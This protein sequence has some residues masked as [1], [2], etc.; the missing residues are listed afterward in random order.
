MI[1]TSSVLSSK[2]LF[3]KTTWLPDI[4]NQCGGL[5]AELSSDF[6][7]SA[8]QPGI[9]P[10]WAVEVGGFSLVS[11]ATRLGATMGHYGRPETT[12]FRWSVGQPDWGP[13][14]ATW[15]GGFPL[16]SGATRES[17]PQGAQGSPASWHSG[18]AT[19]A[20]E[21]PL[22][23]QGNHPSSA[24]QPSSTSLVVSFWRAIL[25]RLL[26]APDSSSWRVDVTGN[27]LLI[28]DAHVLSFLHERGKFEQ[29]CFHLNGPGRP[30][31][32][33]LLS[34]L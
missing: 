14:W 25:I 31:F 17:P 1:F 23:S 13:L 3:S 12:D 15:N 20:S 24:C 30:G 2:C 5:W 27:R 28:K 26:L 32:V 16:V 11:R 8:G 29:S 10:V 33:K 4:D 18:R 22:V 19:G 9:G 34:F 7:W 21:S 6:G